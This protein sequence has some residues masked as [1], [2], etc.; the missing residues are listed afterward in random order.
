[1]VI[2]NIRCFFSLSFFLPFLLLL[3]FYFNTYLFCF[4]SN[5]WLLSTYFSID[6]YLDRYLDYLSALG[7]SAWT[8]TFATF[9]FLLIP[10]NRGNLLFTCFLR[11]LAFSIRILLFIL[12]ALASLYLYIYF[13]IY[14]KYLIDM[15]VYLLAFTSFTFLL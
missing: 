15:L 6:A 13:L 10:F 3:S 11:I 4:I 8:L 1:M 7:I 9:F 5:R 2:I 12:R 14:F